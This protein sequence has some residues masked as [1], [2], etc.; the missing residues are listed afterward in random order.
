MVKTEEAE[1]TV[2]VTFAPSTKVRPDPLSPAISATAP[3]PLTAKPAL[4]TI[5]LLRASAVLAPSAVT[6]TCEALVTSPSRPALT[7]PP[8]KA[9]APEIA[10]APNR[11]AA[12]ICVS[13]VALFFWFCRRASTRTRP[14]VEIDAVSPT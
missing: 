12:R 9:L 6:L 2:A 3:A 10:P 14:V 8:T 1:P 7:A 5:A 11:P 4:S 13:A